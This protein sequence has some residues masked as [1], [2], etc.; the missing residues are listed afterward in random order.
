MRATGAYR[1]GG[2]FEV[3]VS[4][5]AFMD[6]LKAG[7]ERRSFWEAVAAHQDTPGRGAEIRSKIVDRWPDVAALDVD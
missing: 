6:A 2:R 1:D 3:R 7:L 4:H 5:W